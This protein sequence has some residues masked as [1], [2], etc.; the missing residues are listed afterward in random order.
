MAAVLQAQSALPARTTGRREPWSAPPPPTPLRN[1]LELTLD[2]STL[3]CGSVSSS[4]MGAA[5]PSL[6]PS[7]RSLRRRSRE[8][9]S[10][11]LEGKGY[12]P[13]PWL[14]DDEEPDLEGTDDDEED[15]RTRRALMLGARAGKAACEEEKW[16]RSPGPAN[17]AAFSSRSPSSSSSASPPPSPSKAFTSFSDSP[18]R[19]MAARSALPSLRTQ[20]SPPKP[21]P[22]SLPPAVPPT[23]NPSQSSRSSLSSFSA[24]SIA[25]SSPF[26]RRPS[27]SRGRPKSPSFPISP[28][29]PTSSC[30]A[31]PIFTHRPVS[32]SKPRVRKP[33]A[34]SPPGSFSYT[35]LSNTNTG[36]GRSTIPRRTTSTST[37][38]GV[39]TTSPGT[40]RHRRSSATTVLFPP[41]LPLPPPLSTS[42][43]LP[44]PASPKHRPT[45][46]TIELP[47]SPPLSPHSPPAPSSPSPEAEAEEEEEEED[48]RFQSLPLLRLTHALT[49]A[50]SLASFRASTPPPPK[51]A[52]GE[53]APAVA[54]LAKAVLP[55][56]LAVSLG[57]GE[58][59][60]ALGGGGGGVG[61]GRG[62]A[63]WHREQYRLYALGRA[64]AVR[65]GGVGYWAGDA[66]GF[67]LE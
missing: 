8:E 42:S 12:A 46:A 59:A 56:A 37:V 17:T 50:S 18:P 10:L 1:A 13:I 64:K 16:E 21:S 14:S 65:V 26:D 40:S 36:R 38:D 61:Q 22:S 62:R 25:T 19:R 52:G 54:T 29:S 32:P 6:P 53:R 57:A 31:S 48:E 34:S 45:R 43:S 58:G 20:L 2:T 41:G 47:P 60:G 35:S 24:L 27:T 30:P 15:E 9:E 63:A 39:V 23:R 66:R 28:S 5:P 3:F 67:E 49:L 7:P 33:I 11:R 55:S 44:P 51:T 4:S